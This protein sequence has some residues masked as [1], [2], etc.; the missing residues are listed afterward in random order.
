[1]MGSVDADPI[2]PN[3]FV[4]EVLFSPGATKI[5]RVTPFKTPEKSCVQSESDLPTIVP[6]NN[7]HESDAPTRHMLLAARV[8]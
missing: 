1:M 3:L 2:I 6:L 8:T 4:T 7:R 5:P